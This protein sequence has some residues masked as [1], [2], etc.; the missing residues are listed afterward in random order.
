MKPSFPDHRSRRLPR[1]TDA[2]EIQS[3]GFGKVTRIPTTP[4][5]AAKDA[6]LA[7]KFCC[8]PA[9]DVQ[10]QVLSHN[11]PITAR[12]SDS[13]GGVTRQPS[14]IDLPRQKPGYRREN[15]NI[16]RYFPLSSYLPQF[17]KTFAVIPPVEPLLPWVARGYGA[18]SCG[19]AAEDGASAPI[20]PHHQHGLEQ[21]VAICYN[22]S[23]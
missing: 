7:L 13:M 1:T 18:S 12:E 15:A 21:L 22:N 10:K 16:R 8:K 20:R 11:D 23:L 6:T 4:D 9:V 19:V 3:R 17:N 2:L 14:G 5:L